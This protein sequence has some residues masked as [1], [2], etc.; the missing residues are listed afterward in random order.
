MTVFKIIRAKPQVTDGIWL[1]TD[2]NR[3]TE[4][5]Q[6]LKEQLS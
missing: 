3:L 4:Q 6:S 2:Y 1:S 5:L